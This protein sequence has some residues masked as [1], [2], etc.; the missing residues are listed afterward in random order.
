VYI[1]ILVL[2]S[3]MFALTGA[4]QAQSPTRLRGVIDAFDG[5]KLSVKLTSG[6]AQEVQVDEE[7]A[8]VF[9]RKIELVD[10]EPGDFVAVTSTKHDDGSLTAFEVRRFPKP[11]NP[12][13]R[14]YD[15]RSDQTMTN[16]TVAAMVQSANGPE[17]TVSYQGGS[18]KILVP[19][20][21]SISML[22]PG[23]RSQLKPG[24][25]VSL[26]A[27]QTEGGGLSA[28]NIQVGPSL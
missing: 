18:Q 25:P 3:V 12:G 8:I 13:H 17:L 4:V 24:A 27:T 21:A 19:P 22:V 5:N 11:S 10:I 9:A 15:G 14:P 26:I 6:K 7:T 1:R 2:L 28:R 16:A 20:N 23:E